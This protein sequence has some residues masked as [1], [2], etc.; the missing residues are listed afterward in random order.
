[1]MRPC[2]QVILI[3]LAVQGCASDD[4]SASSISPAKY[5]A[6]DVDQR[7]TALA[8]KENLLG[9]NLL[10]LEK[11]PD[12]ETHL[13]KA[14]TA[15]ILY[16]PAHNNLGTLYFRQAK[17]YL[18]ATEF[19]YAGKLMPRQPEPRNNLGLV[20]EATGKMNDA[21]AFYDKAAALD[22]E[23]PEF[24]GNSARARF[25]RGDQSEEFREMLARLV[26]TDSREEWVDWARQTLKKSGRV[27]TTKP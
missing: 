10:Q 6:T 25:R 11:Y 1:M 5:S 4:R 19:Q 26:A 7:D 15:D 13:Q 9:L 2:M 24:V 27:S 14:L 16:G 8:R 21:I 20:F 22:P 3:A 18:A 23:N 12:A 17:F